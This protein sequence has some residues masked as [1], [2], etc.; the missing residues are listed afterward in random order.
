MVG[1]RQK[2]ESSNVVDDS[3]LSFGTEGEDDVEVE[4]DEI[5]LRPRGYDKDFWKPLLAGDHG[6]SNAV[7]VVFN[8]DEIVEGFKKNLGLERTFATQVVVLTTMLRLV[9]LAVVH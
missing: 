5:Q 1:K 4:L 6:G 9:A 7:N 3:G 2:C 8:E